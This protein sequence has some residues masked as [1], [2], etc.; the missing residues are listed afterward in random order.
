[1]ICDY[2]A[3][4]LAFAEIIAALSKRLPHDVRFCPTSVDPFDTTGI[5]F[6]LRQLG[7]TDPGPPPF[8]T[9]LFANCAPR[10]DRHV[11]RKN[12][13]GEGLLYGTLRNGVEVI[14]VNSGHTFSFVKDDLTSLFTT[15]APDRGS[16]FRS[17]D[18]FPQVIAAVINGQ[19]DF[20]ER[21]LKIK[22][23]VPD[24]PLNV[25]AY[26]DSFGNLKT[27]IRDGNAIL[28]GLAEGQRVKVTIGRKSCTAT[29]ATGSFNV[30]EGDLALAPGSSGH[31]QR[32]WELFKRGGSAWRDFDGPSNGD[33]VTIQAE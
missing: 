9:V 11:A 8:R 22:T 33:V 1:L 23:A 2:G 25:V 28:G 27:S 14:A 10:K 15:I 17:R 4:D 19:S 24:M 13:A 6:I 5:G 30:K 3:N 20:T 12:N 26:R 7:M 32:F 29:V 21:E 16:Q 31:D 18:F